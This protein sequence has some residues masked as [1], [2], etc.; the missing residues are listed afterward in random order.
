MKLLEKYKYRRINAKVKKIVR[1]E[2][3]SFYYWAETPSY[4]NYDSRGFRSK[5]YMDGDYNRPQIRQKLAWANKYCLEVVYTVKG[6]QYSDTV[7][8]SDYD[9]IL[10][11]NDYVQLCYE[12]TDPSK[13]YDTQDKNIIDDIVARSLF[14]FCMAGIFIGIKILVS[15]GTMYCLSF[16]TLLLLILMLVLMKLNKK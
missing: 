10:R 12:R 5:G 4:H 8:I 3:H 14:F 15:N 11:K 16:F 13:V 6:K 1:S 7:E 2:E 9:G